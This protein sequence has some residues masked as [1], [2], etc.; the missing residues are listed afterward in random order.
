M[1]N[2]LTY[3]FQIHTGNVY[4]DCS[5]ADDQ[6]KNMIRIMEEFRQ[7]D[8]LSGV[9][10]GWGVSPDVY[11]ILSEKLREWKVPFIFKTAVFSEIEEAGKFVCGKQLEY[12]PMFDVRLEPAK[13]YHLNEQENFLFR[14]PSSMLNRKIS[15]DFALAFLEQIPFDGVFLDRVRYNSLISGI[16]GIGCFCPRCLRIYEEKGIDAEK[17]RKILLETEENKKPIPAVYED[18][19]YTFEDPDLDAFFRMRTEILTEAVSAFAQKVHAR[20]KII[21]LDLF[22]PSAGYFTGQDALSLSGFVDFIKPMMYKYTFAP[23]GIPFE[24]PYVERLVS[25]GE[26]DVFKA[27]LAMLKK[28]SCAVF[29]GI[30]A[31]VIDP[32]CKVSAAELG[33]TLEEIAQ[34]GYTEVVA[35]WDMNQMPRTHLDV[36]KIGC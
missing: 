14:C 11:A 12:E 17:V 5:Q 10:A 13:P 22:A 24:M 18:G 29:P 3:W 35:S 25:A 30:E 9:L 27:D 1:G 34:M 6:L 2:K 7:T 33:Q 16:S 20:G 4:Q 36:M 8:Q 23:A 21:G 31:N 19:R 28:A 15:E 26:R 32:I